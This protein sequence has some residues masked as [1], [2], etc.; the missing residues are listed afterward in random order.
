M[1]H[2]QAHRNRDR[3]REFERGK[4]VLHHDQTFHTSYLTYRNATQMI[5]AIETIG[6]KQSAHQ[7]KFK[8]LVISRTSTVAFSKTI[9]A[10]SIATDL[11]E[12]DRSMEVL[13]ILLLFL[14]EV[15]NNLANIT[16]IKK[17]PMMKIIGQ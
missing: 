2:C 14:V 8:T 15:V 5:S 16:P 10:K 17:D 7:G 13:S 1:V 11:K 3:P 9:V 12:V 6:V 4:S